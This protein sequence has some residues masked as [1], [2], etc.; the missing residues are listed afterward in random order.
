MDR[1]EDNWDDHHK[2]GWYEYR[3]ERNHTSSIEWVLY[4][5]QIVEWIYDNV[6]GSTKHARWIINLEHALFRFRFERNYLQFILK[7]S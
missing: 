3:I 7:W 4:Y 5:Q 6:D 2:S 1:L